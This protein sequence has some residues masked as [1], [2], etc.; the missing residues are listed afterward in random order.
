MYKT[1]ISAAG[2]VSVRPVLRAVVVRVGS[3][4]G[5]VS[6]GR[7]PLVRVHG[8]QVLH[9]LG[10]VGLLLAAE[11]AGGC[12]EQDARQEAGAHARPREHV[13][14]AVRELGDA[15]AP[16]DLHGHVIMK[17]LEVVVL[18]AVPEAHGSGHSGP[19]CEYLE[20]SSGDD[21]AVGA[22]PASGDAREEGQEGEEEGDDE[23]GHHGPGHPLPALLCE[24]VR[25]LVFGDVVVDVD[26]VRLHRGH[27]R[28]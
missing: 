5:R 23:Q 3:R 11:A 22:L 21:V 8:H 2:S 13:R 6:V 12:E 17:L 27:E 7:L 18:D 9:V 4:V 28:L 25:R 26:A 20:Q 10:L 24:S 19:T 1:R 15:L 16:E 14:P